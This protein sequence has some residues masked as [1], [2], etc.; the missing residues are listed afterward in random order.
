MTQPSWVLT[1]GDGAVVAVALHDGHWIREEVKP[2]LAVSEAERWREEDPFTATWVGF[3]DTQIVVKRSRFEF[4][5]N[6]PRSKAVYIK[7]QDAWGLK[8]WKSKPSKEIIARSLIE[9]DAFYSQIEQVF[10]DIERRWGRF[11]VFE[12]HTYNHRRQGATALP[13]DPMYNPEINLGTGTME[14]DRWKPVI[15]S[16]LTDMQNFD[17]LG[18]KL[19]VRENIKFRGG[20]FPAWVHQRFPQSAC[21]L[22]IE[23]KKFFMDEWTNQPDFEQLDAIGCALKSTVPG[24]IKALK[25]V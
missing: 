18:R 22:S 23:V 16:F 25:Q 3:A 21:V 13:A 10:A 5:L 20:Y 11:V 8:V 12:L 1:Q 9:Y 17:F 2:L 4:D 19:D 7:P 24:I 14:R 15:D 6:R